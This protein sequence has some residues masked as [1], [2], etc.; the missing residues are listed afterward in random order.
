MK[1]KSKNSSFICSL[2]CVLLAVISAL[3]Y[4]FSLIAKADKSVVYI[5]DIRI[6]TG[7]TSKDDA[8]KYFDKIG[9]TML[10]ADVNGGTDTSRFVYIGYQTTNDPDEA[11]TDI[12]MLPMDT[13]YQMYNYKEIAEY[14]ASQNTGTA[15][16]M[17]SAAATFADYYD[18]GSPKAQEAYIGLNLF[19][20]GDKEKTRLGDFILE[21]RD[22]LQN[23]F[24]KMII[25]SNATVIGSVT[26]LLSAGVTP[27]ENDYDPKTK[28]YYTSDWATRVSESA[29]WDQLD[30]GMTEDE[31]I[32]LDRAYN[33][34]A[35]LLFKEL[36]DFAMLYENAVVRY[37]EQSVK[38]KDYF[39]SYEKA[40]ENM[41]S[42]TEEDADLIYINA[43]NVL[44]GY[45]LTN[46]LSLAEWLVSIGNKTSEDVDYRRLY[47]V[48]EALGDAQ[49]DMVALTSFISAVNTLGENKESDEFETVL[50]KTRNAIKKYNRDGAETLSVW[51]TAEETG[52]QTE[53]EAGFIEKLLMPSDYYSRLPK[54]DKYYAY[55]SEAV[56][57]SSAENIIGKKT[58]LE[59]LD[60]DFSKVMGWIKL[61]VGIATTLV[62]LADVILKI[63]ACCSWAS[64]AGCAC[65]MKI[66]GWLSFAGLIISGVLMLAEFA[67]SVFCFFYE[68]INGIDKTLNHTDKPS[69]VFDSVDTKDGYVTVRYSSVLD[70]NGE[71][72]DINAAKQYKWCLLAYTK[73]KNAGSPLC[74]DD[75]G[76][77]FKAVCGNSSNQNGYDNVK[78]YGERNVGNTNAYCEKDE[79]NG[80]YIHYRTVSS[81]KGAAPESDIEQEVIVDTEAQSY[82]GSVMISVAKT[83]EEAKAKIVRHTGKYYT[84]DYNLSPEMEFATYIGYSITSEPDK[85]VT[86]IRIAPYAGNSDETAAIFIGDIKYDRADIVGTYVSGS[87]EQTKPNADAL[88]F[89]TD[90]N[91]GSPISADGLHFVTDFKSVESGWEPV[92][93]FCADLPYDFNTA[94][95]EVNGELL[96][97]YSG[98]SPLSNK[99]TKCVYM[100]FE[101]TEKYVGGEKYLSGFYFIGGYSL[102]S[103]PDYNNEKLLDFKTLTDKISAMPNTKI[104]STR[105]NNAIRKGSFTS[106]GTAEIQEYLVY[107]YTYNPE[108][109]I[110]DA[111]LYQG[112]TYIDALPYSLNKP[113]TSG[114][115]AGYTACSYIGQQLYKVDEWE[116]RVTQ[117]AATFIHKGN[118]FKDS[119]AMNVLPERA[120]SVRDYGYIEIWSES[121]DFGYKYSNYLPEGLYVARHTEGREPLKLSDVVIC[122]NAYNGTEENSK[123]YAIIDKEK[124]LD[125]NTAQGY[126]H[127]V[128]ELKDPYGKNALDLSYESWYKT[129]KNEPSERVGFYKKESLYI[130]LR[131]G[132]ES[133][134]TYISGLSVGSSSRAQYLNSSPNAKPEELKG[135]D[136]VVD[137][138]ALIAAMTSCTGEVIPV[139]VSLSNQNDAWYNRQINGKSDRTAAE[140]KPA[141]YIGV[142]RT[143]DPKKAITGVIL[144]QTDAFITAAEMTIGGVTYKCESTKMPI[145]MNGKNYFL[146]YTYNAGAVPGKP[147]EEITVDNI[148]LIHGYATNLAYDSSH[149]TLYGNPEQTNFIHV[150]TAAT[151]NDFY[152]KLY[153]GKGINKHE[154]LCD[155]LSQG[156]TD[157]IDMDLN[158]GVTGSSIY[159]GYRAKELDRAKIDSKETESG[160][161]AEFNDQTKEAVYDIILTRG[162][163]Y[164]PDGFTAENGIFY[165]PV[166]SCD[167]ND[168]KGDLIYMYYSCPY[169]SNR[170]NVNNDEDTLLPQNVYSGFYRKLG[171]ARYDSIPYSAP[172]SGEDGPESTVYRWEYILYSDST[173]TADFNSG[174][175]C[176]DQKGYYAEDIRITMFGQRSDGSVKPTAEITGGYYTATVDIGAAVYNYDK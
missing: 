51:E 122:G 78:Y 98:Y 41:D 164:R 56:R 169:Y 137:Y 18:E 154:A 147:I 167:L 60:E 95:T 172:L 104:L 85:A 146:Y 5:S 150:K 73:D 134:Q 39:Q 119:G 99:K 68:L 145:V 158:E 6:W 114:A 107:T 4:P 90:P 21:N 17:A 175:V 97:T 133:K 44:D 2:I 50:T 23:F 161:A 65:A 162:E 173:R 108:R 100:Y 20:I 156:C 87:D 132:K 52:E 1:T 129:I 151:I 125:G 106:P 34:N 93:L 113:D 130:Y 32:A 76:T 115:S 79:L 131:G 66:L 103:T 153:I 26:N 123:I 171:F 9:Y 91:A 22:D 148:P 69:Y 121:M 140:D 160:K 24:V 14:L 152:N 64:V 59:K 159:M 88:Y 112:V 142:S 84:Y 19:D 48:V 144:Y 12:R 47:P 143:D 135:T 40:A 13:G 72:G 36:Q 105:L 127:S 45:Y 61:I 124:A 138:S 54:K 80:I 136:M 43:Y 149:T 74:L 155:L 11:I 118:T 117:R 55:T 75:N 7:S 176:Y 94:Y 141:A 42:V 170:Y 86:D 126:F 3:S 33:D 8:K 168:G 63:C 29:I 31:A 71:I 62:S 57:R 89:T 67:Y 128:Y 174:A 96:D 82:I 92:A 101:P 46:T 116:G 110:T 15:R 16:K 163:E 139:N 120:A 38:E 35:K 27:Y 77:V 157:F 70:N 49:M 165:Y 111:A 10:D 83:V 53:A 58:Y 25:N 28:E 81:L 30:G 37:D 166:S 102:V 109:A